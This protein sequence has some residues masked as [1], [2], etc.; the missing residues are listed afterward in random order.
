M[1]IFVCTVFVALF[2]TWAAGLDD[3]IY[4][5]PSWTVLDGEV[6]LLLGL[7]PAGYLALW[8]LKVQKP[9][10]GGMVGA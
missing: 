10:E 8:V 2:C 6:V 3:H 4:V 5:M 1:F 7:D 9:R